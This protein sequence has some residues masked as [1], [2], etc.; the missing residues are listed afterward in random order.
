M[1]EPTYC[2]E[3][4][5]FGARHIIVSGMYDVG[6]YGPSQP[7]SCPKT[8][9]KSTLLLRVARGGQHLPDGNR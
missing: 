5:T 1:S 3:S 8:S 6:P 4:C 2:M 7:P 9:L